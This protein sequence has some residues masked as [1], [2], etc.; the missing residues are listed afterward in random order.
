MLTEI[1]HIRGTLGHGRV[2]QLIYVDRETKERTVETYDGKIARLIMDVV[3]CAEVHEQ[4]QTQEV[5][6]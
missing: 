2:V 3:A 6:T 4:E 1:R 5:R